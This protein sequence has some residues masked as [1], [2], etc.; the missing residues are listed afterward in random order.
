MKNWNILGK[1]QMAS[2]KWQINDLLNLLLENRGIKTKKDK[3][4]FLNPKIENITIDNVGI[5]KK[6]LIKAIKRIE[7]AVASNE[8]II[9]FGDYDV[10]GITGAAILWETLHKIYKNVLP[11]LPHRENE[12]YGLSKISID[13]LLN[14]HPAIKLIIT[15]DN[16]IVAHDAVEYANSKGIH[17]IITDHHVTTGT[18][19]KAYALIHTTKLCGAGVAYLLAKEIKN[20]KSKIKNSEEKDS[21]LELA[22]LGTIADLVPLT[23][24]NRAIVKHGLIKLSQTK[25][26][27]LIALFKEAGIENK[28]LTP[29]EA[30]YIIAPRL[31]AAGRIDTAMDSLRLVCTKDPIRAKDLASKLELTNRE[32]QLIL[33]EAVLHAS[34]HVQKL[35]TN[36]QKLIFVANEK[37]QQ[38]VIGLIAG[39]LVEEFYRPAIVLSIGETHTKASAR[40]ISGFNMIEFLRSHTDHFVNVG[41]H[42]MAAGFTVETSKLTVIQKMLDGSAKE[43][44]T[45]DMLKRTLKIDCELPFPCINTSLHK[46][47]QALAPFGMGNPEPT[48][49]SRTVEVKNFKL[50]GK[51]RNHLKLEL[52]SNPPAGE[53]GNQEVS[54]DAIG[55]GMG[56]FAARLKPGSKIDIA[57]T[58][59]NNEWLARR[60]FS[61][62]ENGDT[63]LQLKLKN[64]KIHE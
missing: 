40:S 63:K 38:G 7:K 36:D 46:T 64:I 49:A 33:K 10:D 6:Q 21:H 30:G 18:P 26:P 29:Y 58:I 57:Y 20:Q 59:D 37:Y 39:K 17:V 13:N 19:P 16:G 52:R 34:S 2:G 50:L 51:D 28:D 32:R 43:L 45:E 60:S 1:W 41:G 53:A 25:R 23:G 42:P 15:V 55:F 3:E 8:Q 62:G 54:I 22:A 11:Y 47:L 9:V 24:A 61:E 48:F 4:E 5:D 27:G 12:G 35:M 56:E 14:Q 31:N 44:L